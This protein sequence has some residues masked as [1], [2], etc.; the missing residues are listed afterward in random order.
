MIFNEMVKMFATIITISATILGLA[1]L[2]RMYSKSRKNKG[3]GK[4]KLKE[5]AKAA[6]KKCESL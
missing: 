2:G 4:L 6:V 5:K 1:I 3:N